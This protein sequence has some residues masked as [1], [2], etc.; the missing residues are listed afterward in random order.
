MKIPSRTA[1]SSS[2]T[3]ARARQLSRLAADDWTDDWCLQSDSYIPSLYDADHHIHTPPPVVLSPPRVFRPDSNIVFKGVVY[4]EM[5]GALSSPD[6]L[7]CYQAQQ[8]LHPG[9]TYEHMS[10]GDP[11]AITDLTYQALKDFH[12][13]Y[14]K[15]SRRW[16]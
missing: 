11:S 12:S 10:G 9:T 13:E 7:F 16:C 8:Q 2:L 5:K 3:F 6:A 4:N 15:D 14:C 1:A